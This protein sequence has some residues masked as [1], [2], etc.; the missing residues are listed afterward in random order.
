MFFSATRSVRTMKSMTRALATAV[1]SL[2]LLG[3]VGCSQDNEAFVKAQAD[4]N[5][6]KDDGSSQNKGDVPRTQ[7]DYAA[8]QQKR[9]QSAGKQAGYPGAK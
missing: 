1:L 4:A 9:M 6:A 5:A 3:L 2:P 7:A 8:Q